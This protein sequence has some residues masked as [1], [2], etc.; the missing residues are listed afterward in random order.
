LADDRT[1]QVK[2]AND[3]V[4]VVGGYLA[5]RPAGG[6]FKGLCP[7]HDD[8]RPSFDVDPRRQRY[9]CW[10]CGKYGDV[11]SF[12]QEFEHVGFLEAREMLARRAGL[13]EETAAD[14]EQ[15]QGRARM[16]DAMRWAAK[17][18]QDCFL[19]SPLADDARAYVTERG[20][21]GE[22]VRRWGVGYAPASGQWLIERAESQKVPPDVLEKVGLIAARNQGPGYYDRF[23]DRLQ[24]PIRDVRGNVIAFGGRILPSSPLASNGPKYYNSCDTPLFCK[25]GC[26]YGLDQAR[27]SVEKAGYLAIVEGYTDVLMAHQMGVAQVVATMGTALNARH[28]SQIRRFVPRVVLVFDADSGGDTGVDRALEIFAGHDMELAIATLPAGLDPCDLLVQ[29]GADAFRRVLEAAVDALEFKLTRMV[30]REDTTGVEGRRRVVDAVL[31]VIALASPLRGEAG[32]I[33]TQLMVNRIA[34]RLALKE[35]TVWA[36]L[37]ELRKQRRGSEVARVPDRFPRSARPGAVG[38][39]EAG[40]PERTAAPAALEERQLLE[41]LL[42]D[43]ALV[44]KAAAAVRVEEIEHSGLRRL[45]RGLYALHESGESPTLDQLRP[46]LENARLAEKALELQE[47]GQA[48]PDREAWLSELL[49]HFRQ[50]REKVLK[51]ELQSQLH[52]ASDHQA[53]MELLRR[54]QNSSP[55]TIPQGDAEG[56]GPTSPSAYRVGS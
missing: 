6:T 31:G 34:R 14:P 26:L 9:R 11:I 48:H 32:A 35:E 13:P 4:D 7:F 43:P 53:A 50:R 12:V 1:Q 8:T 46:G 17:Q 29:E 39:G 16:L 2:Q 51:Q 45:L 15:S 33:K 40:A 22:T 52:A 19:D 3:I 47:V 41:V 54:L 36:R 20:L 37:D 49:A 42:A 55:D 5:L 25:S 28:I 38:H 23:R 56:T 18:F 27:G 10:S 44:A 24:F 30:M 21:R